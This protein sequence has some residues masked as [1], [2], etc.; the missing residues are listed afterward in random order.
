MEDLTR[1]L[2]IALACMVTGAVAVVAVQHYRAWRRLPTQE[3]ILPL[4]VWLVSVGHLCFVAGT[5]LA[6]I[7]SIST[8]NWSWRFYLYLT[9][10]LL[11][12]TALAAVSIHVRN[13]R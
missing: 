5:G 6:A 10:S 11:T 8:G 2:V 7:E 3:G 9:G 4:H 12:I 13:R 1:F